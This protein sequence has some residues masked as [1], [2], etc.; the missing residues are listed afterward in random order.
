[1]LTVSSW[2]CW[3]ADESMSLKA[4]TCL[5]TALQSVAQE[6]QSCLTVPR[7][8]MW[9]FIWDV[10]IVVIKMDLQGKIE[11]SWQRMQ[12]PRLS[13]V[14]LSDDDGLNSVNYQLI[15]PMLTYIHVWTWLHLKLVNSG[16]SL[17]YFHSLFTSVWPYLWTSLILYWGL[18]G[19]GRFVA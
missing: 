7:R 14:S 5:Y 4:L 16:L 9:L 2:A 11:L 15:L 17:A 12:Q 10:S 18:S 13:E 8:G 6:S 19:L 3:N 1:M